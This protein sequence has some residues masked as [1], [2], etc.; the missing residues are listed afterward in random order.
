MSID[1]TEELP[2]SFDMEMRIDAFGVVPGKWLF[3]FPVAM[4][5]VK[6]IQKPEITKSYKD[7]T[8]TVRKVTL[9][10]SATNFKID[11]SWPWNKEHP[12]YQTE[13]R[14]F[15]DRGMMLQDLSMAGSG[16]TGN[17][18]ET[19]QRSL[20][21]APVKGKPEYLIIKPILEVMPP[22]APA[23]KT[24]TKQ[25]GTSPVDV[26]TELTDK[27][28]I[29][30]SQGKVG[31]ITIT[32]VEYLPDKTRIHYEVQGSDP[33]NQAWPLWIRDSK[34]KDFD[35]NAGDVAKPVQESDDKYA[36]VREFPAFDKGEKLK[37]VTREF[38][39]PAFTEELEIK[40]PLEW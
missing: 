6:L 19:A 9:G 29:A 8:M 37:V 14:V 15:D 17:G 3:K 22:P 24:V 31:T 12:G 5:K 34:G 39:G 28:P 7:I 18:I 23:G 10:Q 38:D 13:F 11:M 27:L 33:Y 1:P 30:I 35:I 25:T 4:E 20:S 26:V 2:E 21:V 36:F 32:K 16:Y 40:V